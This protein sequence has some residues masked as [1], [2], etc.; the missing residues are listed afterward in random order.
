M[1]CYS[2][3][4]GYLQTFSQERNNPASNGI[5]E[6]KFLNVDMVKIFSFFFSHK[7]LEVP[8][9]INLKMFSSLKMKNSYRE[10]WFIILDLSIQYKGKTAI[11]WT[12]R[13]PQGL[14]RVL[15]SIRWRTIVDVYKENALGGYQLTTLT[16][17]LQLKVKQQGRGQ[18]T[19]FKRVTQPQDMAKTG[20][21]RQDPRWQK[22]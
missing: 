4:C 22:A 11:P 3:F 19:A 1:S 10:S 15:S 17:N 7:S 21:N 9:S 8:V 16:S 14:E 2:S 5:T 20:Q 6:C 18:I 13:H 12:E